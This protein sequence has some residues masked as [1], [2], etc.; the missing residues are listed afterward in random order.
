[1]RQTARTRSRS[2]TVFALDPFAR[3]EDLSVGE[4]Q[5]VEIVKC[6]IREPHPCSCSTN[7]PPCCCPTRS[8]R[9]WTS[10]DASRRSGRAVVLV[11]HK[12]AEIKKI[13][14]RVTVLRGGRVVARSDNP[15]AEIDALVRAMIQGDI[16]TLD[17]SAASILGLEPVRHVGHDPGERAGAER[18]S[19]KRCRSMG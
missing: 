15:A 3:I 8:P 1:M 13:A 11:T 17:K 18:Q 19:S 12:L 4:R 10:A 14:D 2:I 7:R 9:C 6:L 16:E 5:R